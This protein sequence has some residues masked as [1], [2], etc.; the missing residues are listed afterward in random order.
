MKLFFSHILVDKGGVCRA[1]KTP[2]G[3]HSREFIFFIMRRTFIIVLGILVAI[4]PFLG[5][6]GLLKDT[7]FFIAGVVIALGEYVRILSRKESPSSQ[8]IQAGEQGIPG[9]G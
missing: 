9:R 6:P 2:Y 4:M 5:F 1:E 7:F 8:L 3:F